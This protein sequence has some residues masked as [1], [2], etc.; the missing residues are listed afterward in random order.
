MFIRRAFDAFLAAQSDSDA[1]AVDQDIRDE[2]A[3]SEPAKQADATTPRAFEWV[4]D[5]RWFSS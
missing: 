3:G 1:P 2:A 5:W 4:V